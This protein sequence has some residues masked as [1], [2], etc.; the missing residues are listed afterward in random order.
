MS[1]YRWLVNRLI[2]SHGSEQSVHLQGGELPITQGR[3]ENTGPLN[4][5]TRCN[6]CHIDQKPTECKGLSSAQSLAIH[7]LLHVGLTQIQEAHYLAP[8]RT[9]GIPFVFS[10]YTFFPLHY[11]QNFY[12][13]QFINQPSASLQT[14]H[15]TLE[16][17]LILSE[18]WFPHLYLEH[19]S[20][21]SYLTIA[22]K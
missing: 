13:H 22:L 7:I 16:K 20:I 11:L 18:S 9:R 1:F 19:I 10:H 2:N 5:R 14:Q 21:F 4:L 17:L 15:K 8:Q 6:L 3:E 12:L